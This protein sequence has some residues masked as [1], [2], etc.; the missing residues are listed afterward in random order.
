MRVI[1]LVMCATA[2]AGVFTAMILAICNHRR[3]L[4]RP[5]ALH[6]NTALELLWAAVPCVMLIACAAPAVKLILAS[7]HLR[8][9]PPH[10][11]R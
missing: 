2:A 7:P 9:E 6:R 5:S 4:D 1:M 8:P 11:I 3:A 10:A